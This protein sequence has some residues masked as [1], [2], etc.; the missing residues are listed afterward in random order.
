[1]ADGLTVR[2]GAPGPC[3]V[4]SDL[5]VQS[6]LTVS[7]H[8]LRPHKPLQLGQGDLAIPGALRVW[9]GDGV[10]PARYLQADVLRHTL[11]GE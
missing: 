6:V 10:A 1:M 7:L 9:A 8:Q 3:H 4:E 11:R 5:R 2:G